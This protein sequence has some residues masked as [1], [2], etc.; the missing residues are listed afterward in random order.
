MKVYISHFGFYKWVY[1]L[2]LNM[3]VRLDRFLLNLWVFV[4][5]FKRLGDMSRYH[6]G[7]Q[8]FHQST[9][10]PLFLS[11]RLS[12]SAFSSSVFRE[13]YLYRLQKSPTQEF[14]CFIPFTT[15]TTTTHFCCF[16]TTIKSIT[17]FLFL[18][19]HELSLPPPPLTHFYCFPSS[20]RNYF[21]SY[22][23]IVAPLP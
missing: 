2:I 13:K 7:A 22:G 1:F 15:T 3:R 11:P 19:I 14:F 10:F 20:Q 23:L 18:S 6:G 16:P 8:T 12:S 9:L 4:V 5:I 17:T 21:S